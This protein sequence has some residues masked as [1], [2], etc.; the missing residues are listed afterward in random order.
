M[1]SIRVPSD[2]VG[3]IIGTNGET[4]KMLIRMTGVKIQ[5][6]T[7]GEVLIHDDKA[8]DP[9][10][11]L[12]LMDVIRAIGRG[13]SPE[14]AMKLFQ[15]D[16]YFELIDLKESVGGRHNQL[17]RIRGRIIGHNGKTRALIEDLAGVS[18]SVYGNTVALIGSSAGLPVAKHA[19]EMLL[20]GSEHSTV[21]RYLEG[22]R[23]RLRIAEMGFD[24]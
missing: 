17:A 4:K 19:I 23:P 3:T 7:E 10:M 13:F 8:K 6:D 9:L 18:M 16:E 11:A 15:D 20:N 22:Q 2:R 12:K 5:V 14:R 24:I 21:Y 1:R